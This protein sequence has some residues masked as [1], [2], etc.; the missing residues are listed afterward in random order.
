[1]FHNSGSESNNV[2]FIEGN[3]DK[4]ERN[5]ACTHLETNLEASVTT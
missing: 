4:D 1:M 3:N 5:N 2:N